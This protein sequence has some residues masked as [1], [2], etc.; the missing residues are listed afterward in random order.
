MANTSNIEP[1]EIVV[2]VN[3]SNEDNLIEQRVYKVHTTKV[4]RLPDPNV[5]PIQSSKAVW[6]VPPCLELS[7]YLKPAYMC[8]WAV[9]HLSAEFCNYGRVYVCNKLLDIILANSEVVTQFC[10]RGTSCQ[11]SKKDCQL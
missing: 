4:L 1:Y 10:I 8:G 5:L 9:V 2:S 3:N 6:H 11:I 7:C